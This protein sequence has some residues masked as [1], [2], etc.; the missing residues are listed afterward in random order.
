MQYIKLP[1][2]V[3]I[4]HFVWLCTLKSVS[5]SARIRCPRLGSTSQLFSSLIVKVKTKAGFYTNL[6][7]WPHLVRYDLPKS[8]TVTKVLYHFR[9]WFLL[10]L[11]LQVSFHSYNF[12]TDSQIFFWLGLILKVKILKEQRIEYCTFFLPHKF[13]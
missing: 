9:H 11:I 4:I 8:V 2:F 1:A 13:F 10:Q 5:N 3:Q 6:P 12:A 7:A